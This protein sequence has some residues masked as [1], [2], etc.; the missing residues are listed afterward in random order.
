MDGFVSHY[1][2]RLDAKGR[3]SIPAPFRN[4]L[5]RDGNEGLY[6]LRALDEKALDCG[7]KEFLREIYALLDRLPPFSEERDLYA[8]A[9]LGH[10][11]NLKIDT[12]GRV[13]LSEAAKAQVGIG[14]EVTFVGH[15]FKF[16]IWEPGRFQVHLAEARSRL[17]DFRKQLSAGTVAGVEPSPQPHGARE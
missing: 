11:E 10:C 2:S 5:M 12:E 14:S 16:Q 1:T 8:S 3:V 9:L 13:I 17:H 4:L 15:G 6:V 7:G